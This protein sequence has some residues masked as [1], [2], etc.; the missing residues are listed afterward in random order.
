MTP[1]P[2]RRDDADRE[3]AEG[4]E[5]WTRQPW[6]DSRAFHA[7]TVY[8]DLGPARSLTKLH[9][10]M[11]GSVIRTLQE[12]SGRNR[13]QER[14]GL[15]EA[16]E[17][18]ERLERRRSAILASED[19]Q[20]ADL[21]RLAGVLRRPVAALDRRLAKA[22]DLEALP[23]DE[24]ARLV[25][26]IARALPRLVQAERLALGQSTANVGGHDGGPAT[27]GVPG[28]AF[29]AAAAKSEAELEAYLAGIDAGR[30]SA[31]REQ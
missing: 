15:Y 1:P 30:A 4:V 21:E 20:R 11:P 13:W 24:H 12:W 5:P 9:A 3:F 17:D 31:D 19:R 10:A 26:S 14:V 18:R 7:F 23:L 8:R 25:V 2:R 22:N 28:D 6:E 16:D 29:E 27:Q